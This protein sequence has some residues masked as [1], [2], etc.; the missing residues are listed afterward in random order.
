M[1]R[2]SSICGQRFIHASQTRHQLI[3]T[4]DFGIPGSAEER[5]VFSSFLICATLVTWLAPGRATAE[6]PDPGCTTDA[7]CAEKYDCGNDGQPDG[8]NENDDVGDPINPYQGNLKRSVTDIETFGAAP[9]RFSR[10]YN[11]RNVSFNAPYWDFG[12]AST[13]QHNWN[14]EMR[15]LS[16]KTYD[17]WDIKVRY[18]NGRDYNFTAADESGEQF[19][20]SADSGD[21][22][23]RWPGSTVGYTLVTPAGWE[24]HFQRIGSPKFQ[25]LEVRD[26]HGLIWTISHD[27]NARI[28]RIENNFGR[29][30]DI[31][32][33]VIENVPCITSV[34]TSDGRQVTYGYTTWAPT[35]TPVLTSVTYPDSTQAAYTWAGGDSPTTG[36]PLLGSA[37]DPMVANHGAKMSFEYNYDAVFDYGEGNY[38]VTGTILTQKNLINGRPEVTLPLGGGTNPRIIEGSGHRIWR[39]FNKAQCAT[40]IDAEGRWTQL[41]RDADGYGFVNA[42]VEPGGATTNYVNDYAGRPLTVTDP[43]NRTSSYVYNSAGFLVSATDEANHTTS[44]TRDG[45]NRVTRVDYPDGAY[46]TWTYNTAGQILTHRRRN[47]G[48]EAIV[49]YGT[50]ESGGLPGDLKTFTDAMG[51][52]SSLTFDMAGRQTSYT[53]PLGRTTLYTSNWRGELLTATYAD[54]SSISFAY[55]DFGNRTQVTDELGHSWTYAYTAYQRVASLTNPVGK[56][57]SYEYGLGPDDVSSSYVAKIVRITYP[58]GRKLERTYDGSLKRTSETIAPGTT[59]AATTAWLYSPAGDLSTVTDPLGHVT[60]YTYDFEHRL[61]TTTD[62]LNNVTTRTYDDVGNLQTITRPDNGVTTFAYDAMHRATQKTNPMNQVTT[63]GYD[64]AGKLSSLTD[65]KS[66]QYTFGYD[67]LDRRTG[68]TYP[69][70]SHEDWEFD[71]AGNLVTFTTRAGQVRVSTY[72]ERNRELTADWGDGTPD[73]LRSYDAAGR[74]LTA[75]TGTLSGGVLTSVHTRLTYTYDDVNRLLSETSDLSNLNAAM[76]LKMISYAYDDDGNRA[77]ATYPD[78]TALTYAYTPRNQLSDIWAGG[79]S[80]LAS[81]GYDLAGRRSQ[82]TLE[83]GTSTVYTYDDANRMLSV[84]HALGATTFASFG[85]EY[86]AV[87]NRTSMTSSQPGLPT[88]VDGYT[89]D[90]TDQLTGVSYGTGQTVAYTYDA[91]GNRETVDDSLEGVTS[92]ATNP[93]NQ[94]LSTT[95]GS[96]VNSLGYDANGNLVSRAAWSYSYDAQSRLTSVT[97]DLQRLDTTYDASNRPV[98]RAAYS[99]RLPAVVISQIYGAGGNT[100]APLNSDFVELHNRSSSAVDL[101][102]WSVQYASATG[103]S[104]VKNPLAGSIAA[105][106]YYLLRL[107]EG[108]VGDPL[109]TPDATGATNLSATSGKV[110]LVSS[111]TLLTGTCPTGGSLVDLVGYGS[112]ANCFHGSSPAP[113]PVSAAQAIHRGD[114]GCAQTGDSSTEFASARAVPRNSAAMAYSCDPW[115]NGERYAIFYDNWNLASEYSEADIERARYVYGFATD[116]VLAKSDSAGMVYYHEDALGSVRELTNAAGTMLE[117]YAY[118]AFGASIV[119]NSSGALL[120]ASAFGNRFTFAGREWL[121]EAALFDMR[122]RA[123]TPGLG[124][125]LQIDPIRFQSNDVNFYRYAANN[126]VHYTDRNGLGCADA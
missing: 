75:D 47:G 32:R 117:S 83:N 114:A 97:N 105:G 92:Y 90:G 40:R 100:G 42:V 122:N 46:E 23:Y 49:Y 125:F 118:D 57:T 33:T 26:G 4:A 123:Y 60:S 66:Q 17:F 85:Y 61:L 116:E 30:I 77:G 8:C 87:A 36:R 103:D 14:Y 48:E 15:Q 11:S 113:T 62:P 67:L 20:A 88:E 71:A 112:T 18:P 80:P 34:T 110:A 9:I 28:T 24:Y 35:G 45:S 102:G 119:R 22:L 1:V 95:R 3:P 76:T 126:P 70:T 74:L 121:A 7:D 68:M 43:D 27:T 25:M 54:D 41:G 84:A 16:T 104:W 73:I 82:R 124:R 120:Q 69:D 99:A 94:Y 64:A 19:V 59:E 13:W 53:D 111:G 21:R 50:G 29:Y 108:T 91:V 51:G 106:G 31:S 37:S 79:T 44:I 78:G 10:L 58:S 5:K 39:A 56:V 65:A 93:L 115:V 2:G 12:S 63:F 55:D 107:H 101:T 72:D 86:D 109:P 89:Y 98:L 96:D 52:V 6:D 81:Y 38:L